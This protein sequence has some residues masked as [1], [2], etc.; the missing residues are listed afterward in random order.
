MR[1]SG[2]AARRAVLRWGWLWL[3]ALAV[4]LYLTIWGRFRLAPADGSVAG[5]D[6]RAAALLPWLR[7]ALRDGVVS[8]PPRALTGSLRLPLWVSLFREGAL[9]ARARA[10]QPTWPA[11]ARSVLRALA[12]DAA[13]RELE[14]DDWDRV[15]LKL[16]VGISAGRVVALPTLLLAHSFVPGLDA[17][18]LQVGPRRAYLLPDDQQRLDLLAGCQP[19]S[20]MSELRSGLDVQ[21]ALNLLAAELG[22][23]RE[24]WRALPHRW[25]RL[26]VRSY[27][28]EPATRRVWPIV[29]GRVP[30]DGI[31][32]QSVLRAARAAVD[33]VVRQLG[34]DGRFQYVYD[35]LT[36]R[37]TGGEDYN[38]TR[39][40]GTSWFLVLAAQ[41]FGGARLAAAADR[42]LDYLARE[43]VPGPCRDGLACIGEEEESGLGATSLSLVA[44]AE[45]E[46]I[47]GDR[48]YARLVDRL[49]DAVL[50]AQRPNGDFCHVYQP[51]RGHFD[52]GPVR[53]YYS[54]EAALALAKA[55]ALRP[56]RRAVVVAALRRA[57]DYLVHGQYDY[58]L[59]Q[60]LLGEDHWTCIAAEAAWP[61]V[62]APQHLAFCRA[63]A[64]FGQRAQLA[65][66]DPSLGDL[67]GSFGV[68]PFV[69]PHNAPVGSRTEANVATGLLAQR[70]GQE[71]PLLR[72]TIL[73]ALR[74]LVDQQQR[75]VG[76]YLWPRPELA[77]GGISQTPMRSEIRIDYVQHAGMALLRAVP[78]VP[79]E[80][81]AVE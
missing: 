51:R 43:G 2:P 59:G 27:V 37:G 20:F 56:E 70:W 18:V 77:L 62:R 12:A 33:Y 35:P 44:L 21:G 17:V 30:V 8:G 13:V 60:F 11:A 1:G 38:L 63:F 25:S 22:L 36:D 48:R 74:Y 58:F 55:A 75:P 46:R 6:R 50:R 23:T 47:T 78:L 76:G 66:D 3:P 54:G 61:F 14:R 16:D 5:D 67:R 69:L 29:R 19:V 39:H 64:A 52:C 31:D 34:P 71:D 53:L 40:A 81:V 68:T 10:E 4:A 45:H 80:R 57:L 41:R 79:V 15:R 65:A 28:D 7:M 24:D 32:R 73:R 72:Q 9:V 26:R 49:T 42:A